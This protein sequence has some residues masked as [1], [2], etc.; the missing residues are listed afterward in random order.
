MHGA[1]F[2]TEYIG[3]SNIY[4][5][6]NVVQAYGDYGFGY[7]PN[8]RTELKLSVY[9]YY[10]KVCSRESSDIHINPEAVGYEYGSSLSAY[11]YISP[12]LRLAADGY[13]AKTWQGSKNDFN[14]IHANAGYGL[15][16]SDDYSD[17]YYHLRRFNINISLRY[18][19][20]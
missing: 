2:N 8:T 9:A 5:R 19:I 12:R 13:W 3:E 1:I 6:N 17:P 20:F 4:V 10:T 18:T 15:V 16:V 7:Y 11:Y 14:I